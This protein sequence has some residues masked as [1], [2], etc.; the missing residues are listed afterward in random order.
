[1][2][3]IKIIVLFTTLFD[4]QSVFGFDFSCSSYGFSKFGLLLQVPQKF[5]FYYIC[6]FFI[7]FISKHIYFFRLIRIFK[8]IFNLTLTWMSSYSQSKEQP[9]QRTKKTCKEDFFS[10]LYDIYF[11]HFLK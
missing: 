10:T 5:I 1:M 4:N 2:L 9:G 8:N 7:N 3:Y 6:P 11:I